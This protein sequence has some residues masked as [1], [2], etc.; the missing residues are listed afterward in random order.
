MDWNSLTRSSRLSVAPGCPFLWC[1][2][3]FRC[4]VPLRV[5]LVNKDN[6]Y[7]LIILYIMTFGF[8]GTLLTVC[9]E[10]L[11]LG[12]AYDEYSVLA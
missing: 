1:D 12:H 11:I 5:I 7:V 8:L 4:T 6:I 3:V 10:H 9:V 2:G